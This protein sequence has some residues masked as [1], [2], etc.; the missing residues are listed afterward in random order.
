MP[1]FIHQGRLLIKKDDNDEKKHWV[2]IRGRHL[3]ILG[4]PSVNQRKKID[5]TLKAV[6]SKIRNK[7]V[8]H[9]VIVDKKG[10]VIWN[11]IGKNDYI[12]V[13]SALEKGLL[14]ENIFTHNHPLGTSFSLEDVIS[15]FKYR[16]SEVRAITKKYNHIIRPPLEFSYSQ[17]SLKNIIREINKLGEQIASEVNDDIISRQ[18]GLEV[19]YKE[20]NHILWMR[21]ATKTG[22][23]YERIKNDV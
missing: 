9:G 18:F 20:Y 8:E 14:Y 3:L 6:E 15:M 10:K 12:D 13:T 1:A 23:R 21:V 11:K 2:T 5:K 17:K 22:I 19:P 7:S 16:L 4:P